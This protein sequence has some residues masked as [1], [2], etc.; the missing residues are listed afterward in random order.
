MSFNTL[1][2]FL[3]FGAFSVWYKSVGDCEAASKLP[4]LCLHGG[5]G[6]P[7]EYL[8]PLERISDEGRQVVF[9][10]QMGCGNSIGPHPRSGYQIADFVAELQAVRDHLGLGEC[11]IFGQSWGG[12]LALEYVAGQAKGVA[13]LISS[14]APSNMVWWVEEKV[15][16]RAELPVA[17]Q[18]TLDIHEKSGKVDSPEYRSAV[19][20]FNNRH[21]CRIVPNPMCLQKAEAKLGER[22]GVYEEMIGSDSFMCTGTLKD[23]EIVSRLDKIN[24]PAL[25]I[26]GRYDVASD[27][28]TQPLYQGIEGAEYQLFEQSSHMA[29]L[30][31]EDRFLSVVSGFLDRVEKTRAR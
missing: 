4:L 26:A 14:S 21:I 8:E 2:G 27:R 25:V 30:E 9:Y 23:W 16:L 13:S 10:D 29:H 3:E 7:H 28:I 24:V 5:P 11:H 12:M 1:S 15:R 17:I 19:N 6:L 18:Q 31:E 22:I 20:E